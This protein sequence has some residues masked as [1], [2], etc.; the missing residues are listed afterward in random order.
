MN[1]PPGW[2]ETVGTALLVF[3]IAFVGC[4]AAFA[5]WM[6][7]LDAPG[8]TIL[9]SGDRLSVLVTDGPA[10]LVM[11]TGDDP[12]GFENALARVRPIFAR[13]VDVLLVAG[14]GRALLVPVAAHADG[15]V[16]TTRALS[17]LPRSAE[18][19]A[20]GAIPAFATDQRIRL[21]P[22]IRVTVETILPFGGDPGKEFPA[23][24]MT[25]EH[26]ESRVIVL[27]DGEAASLFPPGPP[28]AVLV[29]S[30]DDPVAALEAS[31]AAALIANATAVEGSDL[32]EES[33]GT[34]NPPQWTA[35]V[36]PGDAVRLRFGGGG[37]ELP[38][39]T[40]QRLPGTPVD[41]AGTAED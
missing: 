19:D 18:S 39:D 22:S 34:R 11:A 36:F 20:L 24:R 8:V 28:A 21:G 40:M 12:V 14:E 6:R 37:I 10:R 38:A 17:S 9:G 23:W 13:R 33:A 32:R 35:R 29:V 4:V 30:G 15:G 31:S 2:R 7:D 5:L 1:E 25:I 26:G 41:A 3:A 16:R 27:S